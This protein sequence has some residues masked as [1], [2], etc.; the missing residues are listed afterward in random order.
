MGV[1]RVRRSGHD[2]RGQPVEPASHW[3]RQRRVPVQRGGDRHPDSSR[4]AE[5][6]GCHA[7]SH[8]FAVDIVSPM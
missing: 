8:G 2:H 6:T 5:T 3:V 4:V 1:R 7:E